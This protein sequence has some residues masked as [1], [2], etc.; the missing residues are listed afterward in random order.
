MNS[1]VADALRSAPDSVPAVWIELRG[2]WEY[3]HVAGFVAQLIGFSALVLSVLV[4]TPRDQTVHIAMKTGD[5]ADR[6]R[7]A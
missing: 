6:R 5:A 7:I 2:R 3:G 4:E 1:V